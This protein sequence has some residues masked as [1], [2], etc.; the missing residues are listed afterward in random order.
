[1]SG[2]GKYISFNQ[3]TTTVDVA[4]AH[5][6]SAALYMGTVYTQL[7]PLI[8]RVEPGEDIAQVE[9]RVRTIM[10]SPD[11]KVEQANWPRRDA[12][13]ERLQGMRQ[14]GIEWWRMYG[15]NDSDGRYQQF[16]ASCVWLMVCNR[17]WA[18]TETQPSP[19]LRSTLQIALA[20][21][22]FDATLLAKVAKALG[23]NFQQLTALTNAEVETALAA[24]RQA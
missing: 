19:E 6:V 8:I 22:E 3:L 15:V 13:Y 14:N 18:L 23:V 2:Q 4:I 10:S 20:M 12:L 21:S 17:L 1:M 7:G 5:L 24:A 16:V 11:F 9:E